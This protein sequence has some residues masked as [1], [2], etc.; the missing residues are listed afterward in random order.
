MDDA[1]VRLAAEAIL[2][3]RE[4]KA[5]SAG[6]VSELCAS[7][8]AKGRPP[9]EAVKAVKRRL[10]QAYGMYVDQARHEAA[11]AVV[12][13]EGFDGRDER[14][15]AGLLSLHASSRERLPAVRELYAYILGLTGAVG[16][17]A[18][19]ACGFNPFA[20]PFMGIGYGVRYW[21]TDVSRDTVDLMNEYFAA[22]GMG[23]AAA[24][25]EDASGTACGGPGAR[26]GAG[27]PR[28]A[29]AYDLALC[30]KF[31]PIADSLRPGGA[32]AALG[33]VDARFLA[34]SYPTKSVGG[35]EKGMGPFYEGRLTEAV[36]RM[37][38]LRLLGRKAIGTETVY[39]LAAGGDG[40]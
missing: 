20:L 5:I 34:V 21:A 26:E 16:S 35:R 38:H 10:H 12:R 3:S 14:V 7:E 1:A 24:G 39:V 23:D 25:L 28:R 17:V 27:G 30:L 29:A 4:Y 9:K 22:M 6:L 8:L 15:A 40:A 31:L 11:R 37:P 33:R 36:G 2:R 13:S 32:E 19:V 18:D